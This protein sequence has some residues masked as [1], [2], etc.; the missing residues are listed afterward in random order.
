[1]LTIGL[2]GPTGAGKGMFCHVASEFEKTHIIDT[3]KTARKVTEKGAECLNELTEYFG[4]DI[5]NSDGTLKRHELAKRAFS[6]KENHHALNTITH[7]YILKD[8]EC[9][10]ELANK[11]GHRL[12]IVDAPLLFESTA[13][14][15][16]DIT[17]GVLAQRSI[18]LERI[19]SRDGIDEKSAL[20]R[21]DAQPDDCFYKD[22]C[23]YILYNNADTF[24]FT[25]DAKALLQKLSTTST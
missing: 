12:C 25:S 13:D 4:A 3:D 2:T 21:I 7:K 10:I 6:N 17:V 19:M 11:Q 24:Q 9:E 1:M 23:T 14:K 20:L 16:C 22:K 18:R 8:I 15:L 5:L